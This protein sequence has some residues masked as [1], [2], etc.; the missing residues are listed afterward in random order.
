VS[1][2]EDQDAVSKSPY[3]LDT[4]NPESGG[5]PPHTMNVERRLRDAAGLLLR[6]DVA[7]VDKLV[8]RLGG[9]EPDPLRE[10]SHV[11]QDQVRHAFV[12][13][14]RWRDTLAA[15]S[16]RQ[17]VVLP[18]APGQD[19]TAAAIRL[20]QTTDTSPIYR[21][22]ADTDLSRFPA[23]LEAEGPSGGFVLSD[24]V[25]D[26][27]NLD[28]IAAAL[29]KCDAR[30]VI[31][32]TDAAGDHVVAL[33]A[34]PPEAE[35][36][37]D[38]VATWFAAL[39][40]VRT[41]SL[42]IA[43][44]VLNG[45]SY[46]N[47][48][49]AAARLTDVLDGPPQVVAPASP[50]LQP[51]WH[52]PFDRARPDRLRQ[53]RART[54]L[55]TVQG[56][57]G[58]RPTEI[59]E[60]VED[61]RAGA[62]LEHVWHS[63]DMHR[64]LLGWLADLVH[65]PDAD[66]RIW[67]GTALGLFSTY[68]FDV[69]YGTVLQRMTTAES[70]VTR[71]VVAYALRVPAAEGRLMPLVRRVSNR[72]H[73]NAGSPLGQA[74]GARV[75]AIA[76]G[77]LDIGPVLDKLDRLAI[78]DDYRIATA[79]GDSMGDLIAQDVEVNA[80]IVLRHLAGWF[81]DRW[82]NRTAQ[83][84]FHELANALRSDID[85][86]YLDSAR[87]SYVTWP[88]LLMLADQRPELRPLLI[89]MWGRLFNTGEFAGRVADAMDNWASWAESYDDVRTAFVRMLAAAAGLSPRTRTLVLRH[90]ARWLHVEE[91]FPLPLTAHAVENALNARND[92]P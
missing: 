57:F 6:G 2:D 65:D 47:V 73:G 50:M 44:A 41:R 60:Y 36:P 72:L 18:G 13:P 14:E 89:G 4:E 10:V 30:M 1:P 31:T 42:A 34:M 83:W 53:L 33:G 80:P 55:V 64:P 59:V 27:A 85:H 20:L 9:H 48:L 29:D 37:Y 82:R 3:S 8:F 5:P 74:C 58:R 88:T 56:T 77:P 23:W 12:K 90:T 19:R 16:G 38:D 91:L 25:D 92:A 87:P 70:R 62:L 22:E 86:P 84:V 76:F 75:R 63:Y 49:R 35:M 7:G 17:L 61:G 32:Q 11:L 69:V 79:I 43:L 54:R 15:A 78:L 67:S 26:L 71:D 81:E 40:D 28:D 24:P 39:P 46:E 52:D 51:P 21:L 68:A 45:L 66:V